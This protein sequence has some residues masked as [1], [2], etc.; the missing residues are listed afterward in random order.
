MPD[1]PS[2]GKHMS[3]AEINEIVAPS[4]AAVEAVTE[5]LAAGHVEPS[6]CSWTASNSFAHCVVPLATAN[7]WVVIPI[8]I[9]KLKSHSL[10]QTKLEE[11]VHIM[12]GERVVRSVSPYSLPEGIA[13]HVDFGLP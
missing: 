7:E 12:T 10:L 6:A 11:F 4:A 2:Y 13:E 1:S 3:L 8:C 9:F 5:W